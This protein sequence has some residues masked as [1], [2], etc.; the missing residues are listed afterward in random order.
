M[1]WRTALQ[2]GFVLQIGALVLAYRLPALLPD[3]PRWL[4][5]ALAPG[6]ALFW[7]GGVHSNHPL[8]GLCAA[9]ALDTLLF[10]ALL[11][12]LARWRAASTQAAV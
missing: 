8:L 10:G 4:V 9:L 12:G 11:Y 1:R 7:A 2:V 5:G 6:V 3:A